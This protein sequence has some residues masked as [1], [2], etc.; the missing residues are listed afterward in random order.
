[1]GMAQTK[2][3][4]E[5][6]ISPIPFLFIIQEANLKSYPRKIYLSTGLLLREKERSKQ[7][8]KNESICHTRGQLC[9]K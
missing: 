1:M 7:N 4:V 6:R 9:G 8:K 2:T 5:E 3:K